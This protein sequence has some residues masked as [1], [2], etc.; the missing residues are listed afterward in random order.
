[1]GLKF[2]GELFVTAIKK[3]A[4]LE[5]EFNYFFK[6]EIRTLMSFDTSTLKNLDFNGLPLAKVCNV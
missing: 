2:T 4:K 1:M 3:D 6:I 5:K